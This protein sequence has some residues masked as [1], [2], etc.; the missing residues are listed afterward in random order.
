MSSKFEKKQTY[1]TKT[2]QNKTLLSRN[3]LMQLKAPGFHIKVSETYIG[4]RIASS[5]NGFRKIGYL[6]E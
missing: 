6:H 4:D 2:K 3:K 1:I 5:V